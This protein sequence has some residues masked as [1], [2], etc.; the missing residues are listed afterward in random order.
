M[1][2]TK[3]PFDKAAYDAAYQRKHY[4]KVTAVFKKD[5]AERLAV[6]AAKAGQSR[7]EYIRQAVFTRMKREEKC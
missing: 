3:E 1:K 5:E 4:S 6:A 2:I 7:S